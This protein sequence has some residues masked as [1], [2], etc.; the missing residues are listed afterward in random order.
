MAV[1]VIHALL[2][3]GAWQALQGVGVWLG[4]QL[5]SIPPWIVAA[6]EQAKAR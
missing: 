3:M 5:G 2:M 4:R 6:E 1:N